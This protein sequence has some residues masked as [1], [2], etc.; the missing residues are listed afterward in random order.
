MK[1]KKQS[2]ETTNPTKQLP[3][4]E[5]ITEAAAPWKVTHDHAKTVEPSTGI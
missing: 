3:D 4:W 1:Q 2:V 5:R